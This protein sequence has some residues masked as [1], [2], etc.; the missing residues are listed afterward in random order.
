MFRFG[1]KTMLFAF[2]LVA[3]WCSTFGGYSAGR[4]VR[5]SVL[6]ILFLACGYAA[7]YSRGRSRAF[8]SGMFAVMLLSGGSF[9]PGP[10][11]KY[12]PNFYWRTYPSAP[13]MAIRYSTPPTVAYAPVPAQ[14]TTGTYAQPIPAP[15]PPQ[16]FVTPVISSNDELEFTQAVSDTIATLWTFV[17]GAVVG[18]VGIWIHS[19]QAKREPD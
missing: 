7:V 11:N 8:W 15:I 3:V 10:V 1:T 19:S 12:I 14:P 18:L 13:T 9:L 6:L 4:D 16:A 17:L 2:V 5:A